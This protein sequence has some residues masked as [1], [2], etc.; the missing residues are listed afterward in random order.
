MKNVVKLT[1]SDL[2]ELIDK[3]VSE[4]TQTARTGRNVTQELT[5]KINSMDPNEVVNDALK[6]QQSLTTIATVIEKYH[7]GEDLTNITTAQISAFGET[8]K[9]FS[10]L[11]AK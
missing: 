3:V 5:Q 1:E 6:I 10:R 9:R 8:I 4:Q 11:T 7:P 2:H